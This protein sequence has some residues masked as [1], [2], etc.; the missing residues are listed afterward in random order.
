MR[1]AFR[2]AAFGLAGIIMAVASPAW[3]DVKAGVDAWSRGEYRKAVDEWRPAAIAGDADAQ[4]NLG[5]AYKLGR[6]VPVDMAMAESWYRKAALQGQIEAEANYGLIL[7]Q[8]G[9]RADAVPWLEKSVARGEPRAQLVLGTMLY[10]G[11]GV[12]RDWPRAYALLVRSAAGGQPRASEVQAQMDQYIPVADR[13]KGLALARQ[14]EAEAQRPALPPEISGK[15]SQVAMQGTDLPP[16]TYDQNRGT[17]PRVDEPQPSTPKPPVVARVP[18]RPT[19]AATP[20]RSA[21]AP[22]RAITGR[23]WRLH[24][25]AFRDE[26]NA[27]ALWSKLKGQVAALSGLQPFLVRAG[28]LTKLQAGPLASAAEVARVCA[29]VRPTKTPCVPVA[30]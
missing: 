6:G 17:Q 29:A 26:G 12:A 16:S 2:P 4:F 5:Q 3:A 24:F 23:G 28:A 20:A 1:K 21:P 22:V 18:A 7:F 15:G 9:K 10:N 13:Q 30:P 11:D 8:N 25:G 27:T 19:V 14:Y